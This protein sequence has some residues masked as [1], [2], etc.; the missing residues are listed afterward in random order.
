M[1]IWTVIDLNLFRMKVLFISSYLFGYLDYAVEEMKRQ[2]HEVTYLNY[3][4]TPFEYVY[5]SKF[6][7]LISGAKKLAGVNEKKEFRHRYLK[8]NLKDQKF[9]KTIIIHG[10]YLLDKSHRFLK[11]ISG[12]YIAFLFDGL[13]KMPRQ[14]NITPFFDKIYSYDP[15]DCGKESFH[16]LTN[17]IPTENYRSESYEYLVYNISSLDHRLET[18][19]KFAEYFN[20]H[21]I[22]YEFRLVN[23]KLK[24]LE[25]FQIHSKRIDQK[26]IMP[27]VQKAKILLDISRSDQTGLS[28]RP[29]EALGN[30]K[31][32]ITNNPEIKKMDFYNPENIWVVEGDEIFIPESFFKNEYVKVPA[33]IYEKYTVQSWVKRILNT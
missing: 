10:Q 3:D 23:S 27:Q 1:N 24:E 31:K 13:G 26:E 28:F 18:L 29:F 7:H 9:D 11:S 25:N 2:G 6:M 17:Y 8:N 19:K 14:R 12:E 20:E 22:S 5:P 4:R 32:L 16:F 15:E 30:E 21:G 33:E